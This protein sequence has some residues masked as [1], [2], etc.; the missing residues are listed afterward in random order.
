MRVNP[1][2]PACLFALLGTVSI[3]AVRAEE[4]VY[5]PMVLTGVTDLGNPPSRHEF[6]S[7]LRIQDI[8]GSPTH[9]EVEFLKAG[10]EASTILCEPPL[11]PEPFWGPCFYASRR[12][13]DLGPYQA[14]DGSA[15]FTRFP[16][17]PR[18]EWFLKGDPWMEV[19][20]ARVTSTAPVHVSVELR[21]AR[22]GGTEDDLRLVRYTPPPAGTA[23]LVLLPNYDFQVCL[24]SSSCRSEDGLYRPALS[25][26]NPSENEAAHLTLKLRNSEGQDQANEELTLP[27]LEVRSGFLFDGGDWFGDRPRQAGSV[28][29]RSTVPVVPLLLEADGIDWRAGVIIP[30]PEAP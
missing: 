5:I 28:E 17:W 6:H 19:G 13:F 7:L 8:S 16:L 18:W 26:L 12:V 21:S 23:F 20:W 4:V 2:L 30:L 10:G 29:L 1:W 25:V 9:V 14:D 15:S 11:F 27:P 3:V 24:D 22:F